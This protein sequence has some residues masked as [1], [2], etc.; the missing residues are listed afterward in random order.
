[1]SFRFIRFS[2]L[3]LTL[4][5]SGNLFAGDGPKNSKDTEVLY[6]EIE[7]SEQ[8]DDVI[9]EHLRD[10]FPI[11]SDFDIRRITSSKEVNA[12]KAPTSDTLSGNSLNELYKVSFEVPK[13]FLADTAKILWELNIPEFTSRLYQLFDGKKIYID[14]WPNVVGTIKDKTY[15]GNFEAYRIRNWPFY[16]DP[17]PSKVDVPP[18]KPG[19]GN[20]L[21]LFV[22]HYDENSLRYFHG[23]NKNNLLYAERRSLSHGCVRND[24]DN[25]EKMKQFIIKRVVKSKDLSSWLGSRKTM[26][27]D[28]EEIDKFPVRIIYKTYNIDLD[29]N[30]YFI[31]MFDDI[32]KYSNRANIHPEKDVDS[33]VI[34]GD[35]EIVKAEFNSK[36]KNHNIPDDALDLIIDYVVN[37]GERYQKYYVEDLKK[38]FMVK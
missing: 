12:V 35:A 38:K 9:A 16:K 10:I 5:I 7:S 14:T 24:N 15:T 34:I 25:I 11:I 37:K 23:T 21:G 27:Y 29:E 33:L 2:V 32:Y 30:G 19:P 20:P 6:F 22:V 8:A 13:N 36:L 26:I 3:A 18:V 17:D 31:T 1:M 28:F 4:F